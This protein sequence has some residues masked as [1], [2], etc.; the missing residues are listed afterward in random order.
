MR[1]DHA[2]PCHQ[3][4]FLQPQLHHT[5]HTNQQVHYSKTNWPRNEFFYSV[6]NLKTQVPVAQELE[7][8]QQKDTGA[9]RALAWLAGSL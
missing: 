5:L 6:M 2:F 4:P 9:S 1:P 8:I 3:T 7:F